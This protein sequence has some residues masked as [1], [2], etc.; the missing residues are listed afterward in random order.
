MEKCPDYSGD[1]VY[2]A[3]KS[4]FDRLGGID[5]YVK[6]GMKVL[7]K[8]NLVM[9][10]SPEE[11]ATTHPSVVEAVARIA[12]EAGG[13]VVIADSPGG[14]NT[15]RTLRSIYSVCGMQSAADSSG[16][17]L[18]YNFEETE[19]ENPEGRY[20][21]R[22]TLIRPV[23]DADV[24]I[25]V[26]KLKTHG[27]MVYTGA[28]KNMFGAVPGVLKAEYH[29][30]MPEHKQ[31]AN[32][33]IDIFLST[34]TTLNIMDAIIGMD[35]QGPT[36][37]NPK[38]IG[39]IMAGEDAFELDFTALNVVGV[40]PY[41]VPL[42]REG[43]ERRLCPSGIENIRIEGEDLENVKIKDFQIPHLGTLRT[44][45]FFEN[46]AFNL[47]A[48][49]LRPSPVFIHNRCIGCRQ[50][51]KN[52]PAHII[53]MVEKKPVADM[54]KCIRCFCCQELCPVKAVTTKKSL[55]AFLEDIQI[56]CR[57]KFRNKKDFPY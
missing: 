40:N 43:V 14:I 48:K 11:A 36:A 26:P 55:F 16:A 12:A 34:K 24:V 57:K 22:V 7:I 21:K 56:K 31:F 41:D 5:K 33:L 28:V 15:E 42:I 17:Q 8:P 4:A 49:A 47:V 51:E 19:V 53:E 39:L 54:S 32:A 27:Q 52:C 23:V 3:V 6:Q 30:R 45:S 10:K 1:K 9:K 37:G 38:H 13:I 25:N 35:G 2:N 18:N 29:F 44:I 50:C 46:R 20:L